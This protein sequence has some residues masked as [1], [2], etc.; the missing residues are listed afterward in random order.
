MSISVMVLPFDYKKRKPLINLKVPEDV[1]SWQ[2]E[3]TPKRA[4]S[5]CQ[6]APADSF[7]RGKLHCRI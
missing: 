6:D 3:T 1:A 5:N 2:W 4:S 7:L